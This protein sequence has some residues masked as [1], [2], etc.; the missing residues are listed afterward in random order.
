MTY[1]KFAFYVVLSAVCVFGYIYG[2]PIYI[3]LIHTMNNLNLV[4]FTGI[5]LICGSVIVWF[6]YNLLGV[7]DD[8]IEY[9]RCGDIKIDGEITEDFRLNG[10]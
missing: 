10:K 4:V 5:S 6:L 9:R 3:D 7:V 1:G 2:L 8:E